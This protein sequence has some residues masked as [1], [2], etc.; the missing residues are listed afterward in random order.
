[1][2]ERNAQTLGGGG[3]TLI[4]RPYDLT[5]EPVEREEL[6][7]GDDTVR[8]EPQIWGEVDGVAIG[9]EEEVENGTGYS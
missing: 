4:L 1:M 3:G 2:E 8:V 9:E 6:T 5:I 7:D